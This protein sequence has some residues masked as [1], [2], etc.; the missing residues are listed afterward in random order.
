MRTIRRPRPTL[1]D[2]T[3]KDIHLL[4]KAYSLPDDQFL[5]FG[6]SYHKLEELGLIDD[7]NKITLM[8]RKL[9]WSLS[10]KAKTKRTQ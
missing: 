6:N 2:L 5:T 4:T 7:E 1:E 3:G 8:G 10:E 9:I